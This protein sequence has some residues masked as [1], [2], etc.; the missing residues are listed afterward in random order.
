MLAHAW[1]EQRNRDVVELPS[2]ERAVLATPEDYEAAYL[3]FKATCERSIL[4]LSDTHRKILDAVHELQAQA[5]FSDG[6]SQRKVADQAGLHHSTVG[7]HKTFLTKSAK[8]LRETEDGG[9]TLV[10]DA[11]PDWWNKGELLDGFPR[12]EQVRGWWEVQNDAGHGAESA[13]HAPTP[14]KRPT[15]PTPT[16]K[17]VAGRPEPPP[18]RRSPPP[19]DGAFVGRRGGR[20]TAV[21]EEAAATENLIGKPNT[22]VREQVAGVAGGSEGNERITFPRCLPRHRGGLGLL[23]GRISA[24][25]HRRTLFHQA[26]VHA[27]PFR[28]FAVRV[29]L[30]ESHGGLDPELDDLDNVLHAYAV[31]VSQFK[32]PRYS[33]IRRGGRSALHRL[34]P[35]L[36]DQPRVALGLGLQRLIDAFAPDLVHVPIVRERAVGPGEIA[37]PFGP[38]VGG[39]LASGR[40]PIRYA[41]GGCA[42]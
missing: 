32:P 30:L 38:C 6:F 19:G 13:R 17:T 2:G 23:F 18:R 25:T 28:V 10:A 21:A 39:F 7:E 26:P 20:K 35:C 36:L 8:L 1:L 16:P 14:K 22:G 9:L 41:A 33:M 12:P 31:G 40:T 15:M 24:T 5:T 34:I 42:P 29:R 11:R 37:R 4:N 3:I 27:G